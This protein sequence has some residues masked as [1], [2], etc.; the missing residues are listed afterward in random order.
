VRVEGRV[1]G[2]GFRWFVRRVAEALGISGWVRNVAD[3]SVEVSA[4]G[5]PGAV[6]RLREQLGSGPPHAQ[7]DRLVEL[8]G[9]TEPRNAGF[10]IVGRGSDPDVE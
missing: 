6:A 4:V 2:V 9:G 10:E 5:D 8:S 1:Q 3:G 7:V